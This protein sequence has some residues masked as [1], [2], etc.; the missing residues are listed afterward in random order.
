MQ[1][2]AGHNDMRVTRHYALVA[3]TKEVAGHTAGGHIGV[4]VGIVVCGVC[5]FHLTHA[6]AAI[7]AVSERTTVH[8]CAG[9]GVV[10]CVGD[11]GI[12]CISVTNS[13]VVAKD[14]CQFSTAIDVIS[15]G[16]A[17]KYYLGETGMSRDSGVND[18]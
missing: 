1:L 17:L 13:N 4:G 12:G 10:V 14:L 8:H 11:Y 9:G 15:G 6:A 16:A 3:A 2:P 5:D 7:H 18:I